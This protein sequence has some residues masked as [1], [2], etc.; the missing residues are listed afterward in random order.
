MKKRF[1][2]AERCAMPTKTRRK[3][4][5][6]EKSPK[7][8]MVRFNLYLPREVYRALEKLRISTGKASMAETIRSALKVYELLQESGEN[9]KDVIL[10]D[11]KTHEHERLFPV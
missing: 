1:P 5:N 4:S 3:L 11:R 10:R 2:D 9:G 7:G 8:E 6:K